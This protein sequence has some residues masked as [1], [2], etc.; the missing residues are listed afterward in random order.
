MSALPSTPAGAGPTGLR[1]RSPWWREASG[2]VAD[3]GVLVPIA[4]TLVVANHLSATAVLLPAA[5]G[6]LVVATVYRLP[7]AVQPLKA[8][9]AA[10][11]AAGA[12][13][14]VIAAGALVMGAVFLVL[15]LSGLL[16]R[17]ARVFPT[18]VIR[19]V[20]LAVG[21]TFLRIAW[22]LVVHPPASF[23]DQLPTGWTAVLA[24]ALGAGLLLWRQR[25]ILPSVVLALVVATVVATRHTTL[26]LGPSPITVPDISWAD[27][28]TA[29][30]LLVLPQLPL[31]FANSCLAPADAAR[32]YF[33]D[34]AAKVTPGRLARTL[35]ATN[36]L[37]GA[38]SGMPVCHGAGGM[39]AHVSF[40]ARTWRAPALLGGVL[41][42]VALGLGA[43]AAAVLTAFPLG[44]LSALLVVA[45]VAHIALLRDLRGQFNWA[46]A[47]GTGLIGFTTNLAWA[48]GTALFLYGADSYYRRRFGRGV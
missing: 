26:E 21:L 35:G 17:V 25:L 33:G 6:Y 41:L 27:L 19:G 10:A 15:G 42:V 36:L 1:G 22:E 43:G 48:V 23:A 9:G 46:L 47:L 4:V 18:P 44:V 16:D 29:T 39:S 45:A 11:I 5:V 31:T 13:A 24:V 20:Q 7:V 3:L 12:G 28:A 37:A 32:R 30:T 40:G 34:A 8:F 38:V 14:D 2:A